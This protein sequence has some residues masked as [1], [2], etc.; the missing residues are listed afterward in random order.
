MDE[1]QISGQVVSIRDADVMIQHYV[2]ACHALQLINAQQTNIR[3]ERNRFHDQIRKMLMDQ[4]N[5]RMKFDIPDDGVA[6]FGN[7]I[8]GLCLYKRKRDEVFNGKT[9]GPSLIRHCG[10]AFRQ[11]FP[12]AEGVT[13]EMLHQFGA[14][15]AKMMWDSRGSTTKMEVTPISKPLSQRGIKREEHDNKKRKQDQPLS[16]SRVKAEYDNDDD[17]DDE[18]I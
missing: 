18:D 15:L 4:P 12:H 5:T 1:K 7:T 2:R 17:D 11:T 3:R 16:P 10:P 13:D 9:F 6:E 8:T 14:R